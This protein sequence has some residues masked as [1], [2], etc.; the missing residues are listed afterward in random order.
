MDC[1]CLESLEALVVAIEGELSIRVL[2]KGRGRVFQ[3][4]YFDGSDRRGA[5][6]TLEEAFEKAAQS[7]AA[8]KRCSRCLQFKALDEYP[9]KNKESADGRASHCLCCDRKRKTKWYPRRA[10]PRPITG[11]ALNAP[12]IARAHRNRRDNSGSSSIDQNKLPA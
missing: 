11:A 12:A 5:A 7:N 3:V 1:I 8:L 6:R 10:R 4:W 9:R 2:G